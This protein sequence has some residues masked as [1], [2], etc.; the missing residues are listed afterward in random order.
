MVIRS[1][2]IVLM[3]NLA[4][5]L[6][7]QYMGGYGDGG[8]KGL[9][10]SSLGG[11]LLSLYTGGNGDG[12]D[13]AQ[14]SMVINGEPLAMYNGGIGDGQDKALVASTLSEFCQ[15]ISQI[16]DDPIISGI[17]RAGQ[18]ISSKGKVRTGYNV[19]FQSGNTILLQSDFEV[20][21]NAL[22]EIL[23]ESCISSPINH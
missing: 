7:A 14:T 9:T 16:D 8:A 22:F 4:S 20:E 3:I 19:F 10:S 21:I 15:L 18:Q 5:P 6:L 1:I 23:I 2:I 11:E 13:R 12:T 17:Y